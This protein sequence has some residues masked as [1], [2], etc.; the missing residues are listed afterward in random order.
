MQPRG[1]SRCPIELRHN[2]SPL[3]PI[4]STLTCLPHIHPPIIQGSPYSIHPPKPRP[5]FSISPINS[6]IHHLFHQ[7]FLIHP[8]HMAKPSQN[9]HIYSGRQFSPHT[10]PCS[11]HF[12]P[13]P[14]QPRYT[15]HTRKALPCHGMGLGVGHSHHHQLCPWLH[16]SSFPKYYR[17]CHSLHH[18][19]SS[20]LLLSSRSFL[21]HFGKHV[22]EP[23]SES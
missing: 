4:P 23:C 16:L 1:N 13:N 10:R 20:S 6:R 21:R 9:I 15:N 2:R 7:S 3:I 5:P 18:D 22:L 19:C 17:R 14:I 12:I 11:P 8:F